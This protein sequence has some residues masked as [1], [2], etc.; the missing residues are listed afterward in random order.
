MRITLHISWPVIF[1]KIVI[2]CHKHSTLFYCHYYYCTNRMF[3]APK[4]FILILQLWMYKILI[5]SNL[6]LTGLLT[7]KIKPISQ[8]NVLKFRQQFRAY[9]RKYWWMIGEFFPR[10][11]VMKWCGQSQAQDNFCVSYW[12]KGKYFLF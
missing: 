10:V 2:F 3:L 6:L 9:C 4:Y 1:L 7:T 8:T 12:E 11:A 5:S